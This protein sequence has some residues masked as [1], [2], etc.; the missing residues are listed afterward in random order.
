MSS[1]KDR[2]DLRWGAMLVE[3]TYTHPEEFR[4]QT[5]HCPSLEDLEA[6]ALTLGDDLD[7]LTRRRI[8]AAHAAQQAAREKR[9][10]HDQG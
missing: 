9:K 1:L 6:R 5:Y 10:S 2:L 3:R 4:G 7:Q 8:D